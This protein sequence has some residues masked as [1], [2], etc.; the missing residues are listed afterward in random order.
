MPSILFICTANQIRSPLAQVI[1]QRILAERGLTEWNIASAGTWA[2]DGNP[3]MP[4][5]QTVAAEMGLNLQHH[6]SR[7]VTRSILRRADLILTMQANHKEA[8]QVEFPDQAAR[9]FLLTELLPNTYPYDIPDPIGRSI[10]T[11]RS[12]AREIEDI[13]RR[14][15]DEILARAQSNAAPPAA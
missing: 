9:I 12:I 8:L 10:D 3:V 7:V 11:Y 6:R 4:A 13:L 2:D 1:F 15:A 5:A 14:A